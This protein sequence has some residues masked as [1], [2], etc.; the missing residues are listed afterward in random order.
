MSR[1]GRGITG[2]DR[3]ELA[4]LERFIEDGQSG[5]ARTALGRLLVDAEGLS[6]LLDRLGSEDWGAP[7]L[8]GRLSRRLTGPQAAAQSRLR[9]TAVARATGGG[10]R[11]MLRRAFPEGFDYYNVGHS[12]LGTRSLAAVR[13]AGGRV[14]VMIHDTIPLDFPQYQRK[15]TPENFARKL[16]TVAEKSHRI[17]CNSDVTRR[18]VQ[19]HLPG[20]ITPPP[21][22]VAWLGVPGPAPEE[23]V[24]EVP[25]GPFFVI[26]GTIEPRKGH[27]FLLD[28]WAEMAAPPELLIIGDRGWCNEEVFARLDRGPPGVREMGRLTDG[29]VTWLLRRANGLLFPSEAEGFGLPALEAAR[30]GC[31][32]LATPLPVFRELLGDIPI[33]AAKSD[34]YHWLSTIS[35]LGERRRTGPDHSTPTWEAHFNQVFTSGW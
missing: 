10:L 31:P 25:E 6:D 12:N 13:A 28:L 16:D 33:Y 9:E 30:L 22:E 1:A 18:D 2:V 24:A 11:R 35:A 27:G 3:V 34:R 23:P 7:D 15:G 8:I 32:V 21:C 20:G 17:L 14:C 4:Y 26:L 5:L 19:S 29:Q